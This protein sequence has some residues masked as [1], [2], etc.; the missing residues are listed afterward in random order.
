MKRIKKLA[1]ILLAMVM[2]LGMT[3]T[4]FAAGTDPVPSPGEG[5][6]STPA[7][8][9]YELF[10]IFVGDYDTTGKLSNV[11]WGM[12]GAGTADKIVPETTLEE[13]QKLAASTDDV[14]KLAEITKYVNLSSTAYKGLNEQPTPVTVEGKNGYQYTDLPSGYYL[15]RGSA[16]NTDGTESY[17]LYVVQV[18][19]DGADNTGGVADAGTGTLTFF[20]KSDG[21]PTPDKKVQDKNDTTGET[22]DWQSSAD[23]DIGDSIA[24][25]LSAELPDANTM[26][27]YKEYKLVFHDVFSDGLTYDENTGVTVKVGETT[28]TTGYEAV[29]NEDTRELTVTFNDVKVAPVNAAGG[30]TIYVEYQATLNEAAKVGIEGNINTFT[31]EYSNNPNRTGDGEGEP[32][33]ETTPPKTAVVFTFETIVNKVDEAGGALEGAEFTLAKLSSDGAWKDLKTISGVTTFNFSGLDDGRYRLTE[34]KTPAGYNTIVPV[35]FEIVATHTPDN[36]LGGNEGALTELN[37]YAT[38]ENGVKLTGENVTV[39]NV[40]LTPG[41]ATTDI[42][43]RQGS[44]LPST[45]GIGTTI[46]YVVGGILVAAAG[47]LLVTKRRM[48][49]R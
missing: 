39:F 49:A 26:G 42:E 20:P 30:E 17:T 47:I 33:T 37:V 5:A 1:S 28:I 12:N 3:M 21:V 44:L 10:Q 32:G 7:T 46:F 13:L 2:V 24:Y 43:N 15:I 27:A 36:G 35:Y 41:T 25:Q 9:K 40:Q 29:Y 6:P 45:G 14:A 34:S 23:Y 48:K 4:T 11:K 38:D 16:P 22:S 18:I 19:G 8:T 31:L